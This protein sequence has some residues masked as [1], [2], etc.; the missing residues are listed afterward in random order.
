MPDNETNI[1]LAAD[2]NPT[3][4]FQCKL[5]KISANFRHLFEYQTSGKNDLWSEK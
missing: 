5:E 2:E 4:E 3:C 1:V